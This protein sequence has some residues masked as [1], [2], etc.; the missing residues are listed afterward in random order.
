[1][2]A[3]WSPAASSGYYT[4]QTEYYLTE[5]APIGQWYCQSGQLGV[6]DGEAVLHRDFE[7]LFAGIGQDAKRLLTNTGRIDRV[8]AFDVTLSAP[9]SVSLMWAFG[10]PETRIAIERA[11]AKATRLTLE[12]L[13][14][15][16]SYARRGRG[17]K[18]FEQVQLTAACFPHFDSRPAEHA[19][20][21]VFADPNLHTHAVILNL[22]E[23]ADGTVGALH[24]PL[25]RDWKMA[26]GAT[27][28]ASLAAE[29]QAA[30]F[31][32][33]RIS[34][35]GIFE[36]AGVDESTI[37]YFSARRR[38]IANELEESGTTSAGS[39]SLAAAVTKSTRQR[40]IG[41][42]SR[43]LAESWQEAAKANELQ[44][45]KIEQYARDAAHQLHAQTKLLSVDACLAA[46]PAEL[47]QTNSII[48]RREL[49]R[50]SSA[51]LVGTGVSAEHI[52][53]QVDA[54]IA[55]GEF[56]AL[57][58]DAI[59]QMRYSTSEM[60]RI[61]REV[62]SIAAQLASASWQAIPDAEIQQLCRQR[63][64]SS[65][66]TAASVLASANNRVAIIEG[67]PGSGKTTTLAPIVD[68]YREAGCRVIGAAAAWRIANM[69]KDDLHIESRALASWLESSQRGHS[70]LDSSTVLIVDEAA[71]LSSRD[72][73][74]ILQATQKSGAKLLL[75]GDREQL[76]AIGAGPG[77]ALVA[78]SVAQARVS[79][80]VRQRETWAREAIKAWGKGDLEQALNA[81]TQ[82]KLLLEADGPR[83]AI[84]AVV[85][86]WESIQQR[87]P[88]A[89]TLLIAKSNAEVAAISKQVR[90]RRQ[91]A[92]KV[93]GPSITVRSVTPSGHTTEITLAA[94]D[95]IR[96]LLR[97][98][99]LG[100]VNGTTGTVLRV[101]GL[102]NAQ[103]PKQQSV[104]ADI[105]GRRIIFSPSDLADEKGRARLGWAYA[106]TVF[107]AQGL[108]VDHAVVL[109]NPS[110]DRHDGYVAISR[111]RNETTLVIDKRNIDQLIL[112]TAHEHPANAIV[113]TAEE[114]R[115]WLA[116]RLS[117]FT[118]KESTLDVA[119]F[120][121]FEREPLRRE[122]EHQL[123]LE[124]TH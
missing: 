124:A 58:C 9:R 27:Y 5:G 37:N 67:A 74:A 82:R 30:G 94:G 20:G 98:D 96:F 53:Q 100:V 89:T 54:M 97:N 23:R 95:K 99:K 64:L 41:Q 25:L 28:H 116:V 4:T 110:F 75:V 81:F 86:Q 40:K 113:L 118:P 69:L 46:L 120:Q 29:L 12:L 17:G 90:L 115:E 103:N 61:E 36:I 14:Q 33:D 11:Q 106:S 57:G 78:R 52:S 50:A 47:T 60:I 77:L 117:R 114:R 22:A 83:Q 112:A 15:E 121:P 123:G 42:D 44:V 34:K 109:L 45:Y 55:R 80:I 70:F 76:Q 101:S 85:D 88:E 111:A 87:S 73:H 26:A 122:R 65:E 108:T 6:A 31:A 66:Q 59:G 18:H 19:D 32:I 62:V 2:V 93:Y 102:S 13:E 63:S 107:G 43:T 56:V 35:N 39:P 7:Q 21:R 92:G 51:A 10:N 24:S 16:A 72:M 38:E 49:L 84:R 91:A 8:P 119:D 105:N 71:L 48:D 1:M 3:T 68:A 104:E 79:T